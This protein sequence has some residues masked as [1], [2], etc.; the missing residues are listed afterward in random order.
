MRK[1]IEM[2]RLNLDRKLN[3]ERE[4][5]EYINFDI[6]IDGRNIPYPVFT[7]SQY[8]LLHDKVNDVDDFIDTNP[9]INELVTQILALKQSCFLLRHT[10]H[11]CQSLSDSLYELKLRLIKEL[12]EKYQYVFDDKW[13]EACTLK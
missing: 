11:S 3:G 9:E 1:N 4:M 12:A 7:S 5:R 8:L 10:T 2:Q 13:V 6:K